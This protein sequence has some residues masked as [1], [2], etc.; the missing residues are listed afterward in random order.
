M[1]S[2]RT[3]VSLRS[4]A[5]ILSECACS[6][7]SSW[8]AVAS[9]VFGT[10]SGHP[11]HRHEF[12]FGFHLFWGSFGHLLCRRHRRFVGDQ[13]LLHVHPRFEKEA[14]SASLPHFGFISKD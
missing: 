6:S 1:T 11:G 7:T 13:K 2:S 5:K 10:A 3:R 14:R 9:G 4:A 12:H 8:F